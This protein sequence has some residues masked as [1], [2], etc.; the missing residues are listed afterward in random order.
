[1]SHLPMRE[2]PTDEPSHSNGVAVYTSF[3]VSPGD[4][5]L[6][7]G[8]WGNLARVAGTWP[9]CKSF[10]LLRDRND[11]TF[12]AALSEWETMDAYASFTHHTQ[13]MALQRAMSRV[14]VPSEARFLDIV[15]AGSRVDAAV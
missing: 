12:V 3:V 4:A 9:G 2:T 11:S 13:S 6:W 5:G 10:R 14:C 1:M 8:A 15:P 7:F